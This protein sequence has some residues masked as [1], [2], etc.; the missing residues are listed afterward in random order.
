LLQYNSTQHLYLLYTT[1]PRFM[2]SSSLVTRRLYRSLWRTAAQFDAHPTTLACILRPDDDDNNNM[3]DPSA[4]EWNR[5]VKAYHHHD[6]TIR[7][8]LTRIPHTNSMR[9]LLRR[10]YRITHHHSS[11]NNNHLG[12]AMLRRLHEE[13]A[14]V[15]S[16]QPV[17]PRAMAVPDVTIASDLNAGTF[18]IA[19]PLLFG[20]FAQSI[21]LLTQHGETSSSSYGL[22]VNKPWQD[23]DF[24]KS[25][26]PQEFLPNE[27]LGDVD[28]MYLGGPVHCPLQ[29]LHT[30]DAAGGILIGT[31]DD[32]PLYLNGNRRTATSNPKCLLGT[33]AWSPGQLQG[34]YDRGY[35]LCVHMPLRNALTDVS[36]H[37]V[38]QSV[39]MGDLAHL[40]L[41]ESEEDEDDDD[42]VSLEI[43]Q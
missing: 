40:G 25:I 5:L 16:C 34:E 39:G 3:T 41:E 2:S 38:L 36:W 37:G 32:L 21:I 8:F 22:V 20:Y 33:S 35:W 10:E 24:A 28:E 1:T 18:L 15:Q 27:T 42:D 31:D 29:F 14:W 13:L 30:D 7:Q 11:S 26:F 19:H 4:N 17:V 6:D 12:F 43:I 23:E 9:Q